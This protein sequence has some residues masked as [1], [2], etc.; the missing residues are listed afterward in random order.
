NRAREAL[1]VIEDYSRFVLDDAFLSGELK[2]LRHDLSQAVA[3]LPAGVLLEARETLRDVGTALATPSE[4]ERSSPLAVG[5]ATL[6]RLQEA[7]RSLEEF[8]KLTGPGGIF[9]SGGVLPFVETME[10]LRYRSYTLERAFVLGAA[11]RERL[12][13]ARLMVLLTGATCQAALDWTI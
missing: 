7:L 10:R 3:G 5:Q 12:A 9:G 13:N 8:G 6:K 4:R 2:T 1:R 11:S